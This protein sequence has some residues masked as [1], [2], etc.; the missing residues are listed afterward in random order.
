MDFFAADVRKVWDNLGNN[1]LEDNS[2]DLVNCSKIIK[3]KAG[4]AYSCERMGLKGLK[5][6]R[7]Y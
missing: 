4:K 7:D 5:I 3:N 6:R 1:P 2:Y